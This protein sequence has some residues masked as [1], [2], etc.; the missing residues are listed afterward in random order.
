MG[1]WLSTLSKHKKGNDALPPVSVPDVNSRSSPAREKRQ[2]HQT[3]EGE[4]KIWTRSAAE[5]YPAIVADLFGLSPSYQA[6]A[7]GASVVHRYGCPYHVYETESVDESHGVALVQVDPSS[8]AAVV[9]QARLANSVKKSLIVLFPDA[10][11][12]YTSIKLS[13]RAEI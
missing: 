3:D 1:A 12:K 9:R 11:E 4:L 6:I 5:S 8:N 13:Y 10:D 7:T 2:R